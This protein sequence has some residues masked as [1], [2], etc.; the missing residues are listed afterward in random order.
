MPRNTLSTRRFAAV[1][2]HIV[3]AEASDVADVQKRLDQARK[4]VAALELELGLSSS[5]NSVLQ[6]LA[7]ADPEMARLVEL[8]RSRQYRGIE[9]VGSEVS[10]LGFQRLVCLT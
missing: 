7:E 5:Q 10:G 8:E 6:T 1:R 2:N 4:T 3:P 9:L